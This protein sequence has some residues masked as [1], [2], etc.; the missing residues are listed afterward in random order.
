MY[1]SAPS[2]DGDQSHVTAVSD[3]GNVESPQLPTPVQIDEPEP[4]G[5]FFAEWFKVV[6]PNAPIAEDQ[7][8]GRSGWAL[9][10]DNFL[11]EEQLDAHLKSDHVLAEFTG[12]DPFKLSLEG[13]V[14]DEE[15]ELSSSD[16]ED[17]DL[18]PVGMMP[19]ASDWSK[20]PP[21]LPTLSEETITDLEVLELQPQMSDWSKMP[22]ILP[23]LPLEPSLT[24]PE[25]THRTSDYV[26]VVPQVP[27]PQPAH[28]AFFPMAQASGLPAGQIV[29]YQP[30]YQPN[31]PMLQPVYHLPY[32][33]LGSTQLSFV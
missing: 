27:P 2:S 9:E 25:M 19:L 22:D 30:M 5:S 13:V 15:S 29:P 7:Y 33:V 12:S 8:F 32:I 26:Y 1:S 28:S 4:D 20:M 18:E 31:V 17:L 16:L 3:S 11:N 14:S 23:P 6:D 21:I 24:A 10:P